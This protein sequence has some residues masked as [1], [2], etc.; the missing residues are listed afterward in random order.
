MDGWVEGGMDG[1]WIDEWTDGG[2]EKGIIIYIHI[3][4]KYIKC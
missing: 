3:I 4:H 2:M 1:C